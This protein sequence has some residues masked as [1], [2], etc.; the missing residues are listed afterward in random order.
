V[1]RGAEL[2]VLDQFRAFFEGRKLAKRTAITLLYRPEAVLDVSV[3]PQ[4]AAD[5]SGAA[6]DISLPSASLCRALFEVYMGSSPVIPEAKG[7]WARGARGL[8]ES[9]KVRRDTRK[10]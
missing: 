5:L 4:Q 10:S 2:A 1:L 9:D 8:L 7:E 6:P 3:R